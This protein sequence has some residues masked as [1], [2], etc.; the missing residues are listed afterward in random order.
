MTTLV[1]HI[2]SPKTGSS[3]I[4]A[5]FAPRPWRLRSGSWCLLPTNPYR[6]AEPA[7]CIAALYQPPED[8]PRVWAQRRTAHPARFE[9]DLARYRAL[10]QRRVQP[11]WRPHPQAL[12]LSSEYLWTFSVDLIEQL[13]RDWLALG[14]SR[15]LVVAY[16]RSPIALYRSALQQHAK[17]SSNWRRF[18][19]HRWTYRFRQRLEAWRHV[20]GADLIVRPFDRSQLYRGCVVQDLAHTIHTS[21]VDHPPVPVARGQMAVNESVSVEELMAM[22]ELMRR[23]PAQS[24]DGS[25]RRSEVLWALWKRLGR[26][27]SEGGGLGTPV[28]LQPRVEDVIQLRHQADLDWLSETFAVH[29]P[30][31]DSACLSVASDGTADGWSDDL[32][33]ADLLQLDVQQPWLERLRI[34]LAGCTLP[35]D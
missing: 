17:L 29:L 31:L 26:L 19:P 5:A 1:L 15:F 33:L 7:G 11:R 25:L 12:F 3:A 6:H 22:Q 20:F 35:A 32:S 21:L 28:A 24:G 4:Q 27:Q 34:E 30:G 8:L 14:V 23:C 13:R 10:L 18:R 9:R 2:G 16:V